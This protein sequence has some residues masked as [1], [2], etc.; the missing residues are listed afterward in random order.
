MTAND[1]NF[2]DP[3]EL[4]EGDLRLA[5]AEKGCKPVERPLFAFY[6]FEMRHV[7][8]ELLMGK[9]TLRIGDADTVLRYPGH[10]GYDVEPEYRGHRYAV[11]SVRMLLPLARQHGQRRV[12][13]GCPP[14][15][16]ASQRTCELAGGIYCET[17]PVPKDSDLYPQGIRFLCRYYI[18]N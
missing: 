15:N 5:L 10:L 14:D 6:K 18:D 13:V 17:I 3:G 16:V 2:V 12:W 9:I 11:R 7:D 8:D 4:V 1:F